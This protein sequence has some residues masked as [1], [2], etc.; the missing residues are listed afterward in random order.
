MRCTVPSTTAPTS[1]SAITPPLSGGWKHA[2]PAGKSLSHRSRNASMVAIS[3]CSFRR[4]AVRGEC[5]ASLGHP[6]ERDLAGADH[7]QALPGQSLQL[8]GVLE[9]VDPHLQTAALPLQQLDPVLELTDAGPLLEVLL[10]G[11]DAGGAEDQDHRGQ[12]RCTRR[13]AWAQPGHGPTAHRVN[14]RNGAVPA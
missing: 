5:P 10:G 1:S 4:L 8:L 6:N 13:Q 14:P 12:H 9:A 2:P 7:A 11:N 3:G